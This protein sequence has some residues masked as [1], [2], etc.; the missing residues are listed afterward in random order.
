MKTVGYAALQFAK[1]SIVIFTIVS[2][3]MYVI[4]S[5]LGVQSSN[6]SSGNATLVI[7]IFASA[8][9]A[10]IAGIQSLLTELPQKEPLQPK[11]EPKVKGLYWIKTRKRL[12]TIV[13]LKSTAATFFLNAIGWG[14]YWAANG[15]DVVAQLTYNLEYLAIFSVV[16]GLFFGA[17]RVVKYRHLF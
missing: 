1:T 15:H 12:F 6:A 7:T 10:L 13:A 16:A 17:M 11:V 8:L 3:A 9:I 5:T 14:L 2:I 4:L